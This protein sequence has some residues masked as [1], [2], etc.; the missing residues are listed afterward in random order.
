MSYWDVEPATAPGGRTVPLDLPD[1][2]LTLRTERGVFAG[3]R[4]DRGT[5]ALLRAAP[6]P[7]PHQ[8]VIDL[9]TGYGP[10]ALTLA[11]RAPQAVIW[12]VD[13][14]RRALRLTAQNARHLDAPGVL[15]AEPD[16][17]PAMLRFDGL[18]S[19]PPIKIG[20]EPL[21][22]LLLDWLGRLT[23]GSRAW[24]V[25]KQNMGADSLQAW[26][27]EPAFP[28]SRVGSKQGYRLLRVDVPGP[29]AGNLDPAVLETLAHDTGGPWRVLGHLAGGRS[30]AVR[31]VGRGRVRAVLKIKH[32][33]WWTEQ[34]ERLRAVSDDLRRLGYPTPE[35]L[36]AGPLPDG[37]AYLLTEF[38]PGRPPQVATPAQ[39]D[40]LLE[41]VA[42]HG[43]VH[44]PATRDWS[45]MVTAFLNGGLTEAQFHPT[46]A[47]PAAAALALIAH[48]V[49]ALPTGGLVHG[50]FTASNS[51]FT[52]DRL[53]GIIDLEGFGRGTPAI[54]IVAL[55]ARVPDTAAAR[56][57]MRRAVE[58]V[59][60]DV[61]AA[62]L[63]HRVLAVLA[64]A[65]EHP[66]LLPGAAQHA[67]RLLALAP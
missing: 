13:R 34:L 66:D 38:L 58:L 10:I 39:L 4:V 29:A 28:T 63:A 61:A 54:D 20:K 43:E 57:M 23:G 65:S 15:P 11:R 41:A 16:E 32:G 5:L 46:L 50:D 40:R 51:L 26:L 64:W 30:D 44:P 9:G 42:L 59:G 17:V 35:V 36:A 14:N 31:L 25:V 12:A 2:H 24:L 33:Q 21:H 22:E 7:R 67:E 45:V 47:R 27:T 19:N 60:A 3:S 37:R 52:G 18:Y 55:L 56:R 1:L 53:T 62:C 48:P 6:V 49:P 8:S